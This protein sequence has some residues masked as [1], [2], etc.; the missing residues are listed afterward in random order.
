MSRPG[1]PLD[2][3]AVRQRVPPLAPD[4]LALARG[5]RREEIL[6]AA[7]AVVEPVE[8]LVVPPQETLA[9][10]SASRSSC[11]RNVA[12]I[13]EAPVWSRSARRPAI[14]SARISA[15][16]GPFGTR[17]RGPVTGVNGTET[18]SFG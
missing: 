7:V 11:C 4:R 18:W 5:E 14:R 1:D 15:A 2:G 9:R 12:W 16:R 13:E 6:E 8:L 3:D 10:R 17:R